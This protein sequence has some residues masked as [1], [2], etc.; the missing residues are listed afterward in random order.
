MTELSKM[1]RDLGHHVAVI[2]GINLDIKGV[3]AG[4]LRPATSNPGTVYTSAGGVGRNIAHN[5]AL[6]GVPVVLLGVVGDDAIGDQL[7]DELRQVGVDVEHVRRVE[8]AQT[9]MYLS[10]LNEQHDLA[11]AISGMAATEA[12]DSDYLAAHAAILE[13]S[14]FVVTETNVPTA[15]LATL[16]ALCGQT[17]I[18]CLIEPVSIEKSRKILDLPGGWHYITPNVAELEALSGCAVRRRGDVHAACRRLSTRCRTVLVTQGASGVYRFTSASESGRQYSASPTAVVDSTGAGDAFVAGF[19]SGIARHH[20]ED[21]AIRIGMAAA[22][23]TL[24][25]EQTVAPDI[26][27]SR[28]RDLARRNSSEE[29]YA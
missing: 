18:P 28:C 4:T 6:L 17:A 7:L 20:P 1:R 27:Y 21:G 8:A 12:L 29:S 22:R 11:L 2:G 16:L 14:A 9:G 3:P 10:I 13:Q 23:L 25:S 24:Q 19:V 26:S 5:L 15:A